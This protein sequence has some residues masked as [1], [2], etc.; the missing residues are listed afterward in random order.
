[1]RTVVLFLVMAA[2]MMVFITGECCAK[3]VTILGV[4]EEITDEILYEWVSILVERKEN[5]KL[6]PPSKDVTDAQTRIDDFRDV[7][8]LDKKYEEV[9]TP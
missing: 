6:L 2:L 7:N 3:D 5:Q 4:P 8:G 9:I 1:M